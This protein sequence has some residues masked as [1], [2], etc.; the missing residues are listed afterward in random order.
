MFILSHV[1]GG[2][3]RPDHS[4]VADDANEYIMLPPLNTVKFLSDR[5]KFYVLSEAMT[6]GNR[7]RRLYLERMAF[8]KP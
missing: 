3:G 5:A 7:W 1:S 2:A 4:T 6:G 8:N